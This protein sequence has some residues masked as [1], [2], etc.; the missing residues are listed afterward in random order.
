[1]SRIDRQVPQEVF[2]RD[3]AKALLQFGFELGLGFRTFISSA[4]AFVLAGAL[5]LFNPGLPMSLG[6]G[7]SFG[8]GRTMIAVL[9][10]KG[11][12]RIEGE[13]WVRRATFPRVTSVAGT[14]SALALLVAVV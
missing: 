2:L 14:V 9:R 12:W 8:A 10:H 4:L 5:V 6:V 7:A 13:L 3:H 11:N 1:M